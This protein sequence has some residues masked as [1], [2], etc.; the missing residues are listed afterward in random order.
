MLRFRIALALI[1]LSTPIL[2]P[3]IQTFAQTK[4]CPNG[5]DFEGVDREFAN[6]CFPEK[7][8]ILNFEA[9][10]LGG[11]AS[12]GPMLLAW[13][14]VEG[15]SSYR[16]RDRELNGLATIFW[17]EREEI[18]VTPV[19][20]GDTPRSRKAQWHL[21]WQAEGGNQGAVCALYYGRPQGLSS[22]VQRILYCSPVG[23]DETHASVE[24]EFEK[25]MQAVQLK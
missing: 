12:S 1:L 4:E 22:L 18:R 21:D 10:D 16:I 8:N 17:K 25:F 9:A 11:I 20:W 13:Y 15:P 24:S 6:L 3:P 5:G 7:F 19:V 23:Q 14:S 2:M